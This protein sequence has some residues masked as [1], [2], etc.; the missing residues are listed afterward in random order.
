MDLITDRNRAPASRAT[1]QRHRACQTSVIPVVNHHCSNLNY[2]LWYSIA[3]LH[4]WKRDG[5]FRAIFSNNFSNRFLVSEA[6][7]WEEDTCIQKKNKYFQSC[8]FERDYKLNVTNKENKKNNILLCE[9]AIHTI[10][11][12]MWNKTKIIM[13]HNDVILCL[14]KKLT[15][16]FLWNHSAKLISCA[17]AIYY[18]VI[19]QLNQM[20]TEERSHQKISKKNENHVITI[21]L[22]HNHVIS[23]VQ[24][25]PI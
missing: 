22:P 21:L 4:R 20:Q 23:S 10:P 17:R 16:F 1:H 19:V 5:N 15:L 12:D 7:T 8:F 6:F 14:E 3:S 13:I 24:S 18:I 9:E 25:K 2:N 11:T